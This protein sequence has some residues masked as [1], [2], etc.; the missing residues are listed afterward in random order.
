[1]GSVSSIA[2]SGISAAQLRLDAASHNIANWQTPNFHREEVTQRELPD[3]GVTAS[4]DQS[5][6]TVPQLNTDVVEQM[7]AGYTFDANLRTLR[8]EQDMLGTLID[9]TA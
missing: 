4:V 1:M 3:G 9:V 7:S 8:T 6:S 5:E 2:I